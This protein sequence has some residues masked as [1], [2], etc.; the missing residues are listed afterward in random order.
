MI[1]QMYIALLKPEKNTRETVMCGGHYSRALYSNSVTTSSSATINRKG[2]GGG[3]GLANHSGGSSS[4]PGNLQHKS[5]NGNRG[6]HL[7][8]GN[9][10]AI[11]SNEASSNSSELD[12]T[13]TTAAMHNEACKQLSSRDSQLESTS[14]GGE[15]ITAGGGGGEGSVYQLTSQNGGSANVLMGNSA[16]NNPNTSSTTHN[17]YRPNAHK[18]IR[19]SGSTVS[20]RALRSS[21][22]CSARSNG[23]S[24]CAGIGNGRRE[25]WP[26]KVQQ[27]LDSSAGVAVEPF[28]PLHRRQISL[29][30]SSRPGT[31]PPLLPI[32]VQRSSTLLDDTSSPSPP[33]VSPLTSPVS[34]LISSPPSTPPPLPL[35]TTT[36]PFTPDSPSSISPS[37]LRPLLTL[38]ASPPPPS[39]SSPSSS[40]FTNGHFVL[41]SPSRVPNGVGETIGALSSY[42]IDLALEQ[43]NNNNNNNNN[44]NTAVCQ[45]R[46]ANSTSSPV[47]ATTTSP[48]RNGGLT[49]AV[50]G[51]TI[52]STKQHL[53]THHTKAVL[54]N[55]HERWPS[56]RVLQ[57]VGASEM[58]AAAK[59]NGVSCKKR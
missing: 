50:N 16:T 33:E 9:N 38:S 10:S 52:S 49:I 5:S 53:K 19:S 43:L 2:G 18:R 4:A 12:T 39:P 56:V 32:P 57:E 24:A 1:E 58:V 25:V 37:T 41:A 28:P 54:E 29:G 15:S 23:E 20:E 30:I 3:G 46:G 44:S 36:I 21:S 14:V 26:G 42:T 34:L 47:L 17:Y 7:G 6:R 31:P 8:Q 45:F 40:S 22:A 11:I 55:G 35:S 48:Q 13:T 51:G 27:N 59:T